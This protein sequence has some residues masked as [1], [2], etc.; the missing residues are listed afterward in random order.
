MG[1]AGPVTSAEIRL[2]QACAPPLCSHSKAG[3]HAKLGSE[4][5]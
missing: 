4:E 5:A 1:A 3:H 2:N